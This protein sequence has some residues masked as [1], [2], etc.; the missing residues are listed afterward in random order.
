MT[1]DDAIRT[2][3]DDAGV[4]W[5]EPAPGTYVASLP[6]ERRLRTTVALVL[7]AHS[8]TVNAFVVRRPDENAEGVYR[9]LLERNARAVG[10]AYAIDHL[11]DVYLVGRL[12]CAA[13]T[14]E[15]VD[16]LL[17]S[18]HERADGAFNTLLELGF[19]SSIRKEHAW[20]TSRGVPTDNLA[21][22]AHL[23][24]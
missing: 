16:A 18:V 10:V 12:P 21:A 8:L 22:F 20:R 1:P 11:G 19:A 13:V 4:E 23:I 17:G 14:P 24:D 2:A 7:G 3:L 6:G 5:E 15:A 9:W